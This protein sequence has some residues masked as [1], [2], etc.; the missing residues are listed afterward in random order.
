M[1]IKIF[2]K[3]YDKSKFYSIM[4]KFFA[5][6]QY[7]KEMPYMTNKDS[8]VWFL[9]YEMNKLLGFGAINILQNKVVFES[10]FEIEEHRKLSVCKEINKARLNYVKDF[11]KE[12]E[13]IENK[14]HAKDYWI[15]KGFE[16]SKQKGNYYFLVRSEGK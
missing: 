2:D 7:K 5:E 4:G 9:C 1:Q 10:Y 15:K 12:I 14:E 13:I 6:P 11:K 3:D 8:K 16:I